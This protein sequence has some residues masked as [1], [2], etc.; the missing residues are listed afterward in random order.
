MY[1]C[2]PDDFIIET[3]ISQQTVMSYKINPM[4]FSNICRNFFFYILFLCN[5]ILTTFQHGKKN[6][7]S[8]CISCMNEPQ[9]RSHILY[10]HYKR[11]VMCKKKIFSMVFIQKIQR[12]YTNTTYLHIIPEI[13]ISVS[14]LLNLIEQKFEKKRENMKQNFPKIFIENVA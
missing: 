10:Q 1:S 12:N 4:I 13:F 14:I 2:G 11:K 7:K 5:F 3:T 6:D 9:N 8:I